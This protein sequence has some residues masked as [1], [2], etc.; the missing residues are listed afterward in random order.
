[1]TDIEPTGELPVIDPA[2]ITDENRRPGPVIG[3]VLAAGTSTRYGQSNKLL[4]TVDGDPI[5]RRAVCTLEAS[6]VDSVLVVCGHEADG[7]RG[8]LTESGAEMIDNPDYERGQSTSVAAGLEAAAER[9]ASA[10]VIALGDMPNVAVRSVNTL[11]SAYR[12]DAGDALAAAY[13]GTRGNPVCFARRHFD[14]LADVSGDM[15]GR[16]ILLADD[17][18]ALIETDDPGVLYDVDEPADLDSAT[19]DP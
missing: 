10:V 15:G 6:A 3:V 2:T 12:A 7:V 1:M 17:R 16:T 5:V 18:S 11:A 13:E 8:A 9:G 4:A 14:A 19:G